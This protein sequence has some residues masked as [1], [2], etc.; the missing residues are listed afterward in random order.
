MTEHYCN[1]E[2]LDESEETEETPGNVT[3]SELDI[4]DGS[5]ARNIKADDALLAKP[6]EVC[7]NAGEID[8][9][10]IPINNKQYDETDE[11]NNRIQKDTVS[12]AVVSLRGML[13]AE[14]EENLRHKAEVRQLKEQLR[15]CRR[16]CDRRSRIIQSQRSQIKS[17]N[18][19]LK[20]VRKTVRLDK[21]LLKRLKQNPAIY[22]SLKNSARKPKGR[23]Y[24]AELKK[25][26]VS[27]Y[28]CG[29]RVYRMMRKSKVLCLPVKRTIKRWTKDVQIGPGLNEAILEQIKAKVSAFSDK[30]RVVV[31]AIDG[32]KVK[33][34]LTYIAKSDQFH[35]FPDDGFDRRIE[36]NNPR[37]LATEAV[38]VMVRGVFTKFK[39]VKK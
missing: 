19:Q 9:G 26:A 28:L 33:P 13:K 22:N 7:Q 18:D 32:M 14:K 6:F 21:N 31:L 38:T 35:G 11:N 37:Y 2:Y 1:I 20:Q 15:A 25:F 24:N 29:P 34:G 27:S 4:I 39:Q 10:T 8:D 16:K 30:E 3:F 23:R 36:Q 5:N 17:L 12:P